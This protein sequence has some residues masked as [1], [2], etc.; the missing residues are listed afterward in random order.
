VVLADKGEKRRMQASRTNK[1]TRRDRKRGWIRKASLAPHMETAKELR[2]AA[3]LVAAD[4]A[5]AA[6]QVVL[7][8]LIRGVQADYLLEV[9]TN[10]QLS[11][12][13]V[14]KRLH[15]SLYAHR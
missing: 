10:L 11:M 13:L 5:V 6:D 3:D 1:A 14:V 2:D 8:E 4:P 15:N 12:Q 7:T 9:W